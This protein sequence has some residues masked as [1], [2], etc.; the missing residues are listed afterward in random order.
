[1]ANVAP[2]NF[3]VTPSTARSGETLTFQWSAGSGD[4]VQYRVWGTKSTGGFTAS[5][6]VD[7][8]KLTATGTYPTDI[9]DGGYVNYR[10]SLAQADGGSI[11]SSDNFN[12]P[13]VAG[14][15]ETVQPPSSITVPNVIKNQSITIT[16]SE[17]TGATSYTLQRLVNSGSFET[18]YTGTALSYTDTVGSN[19]ETVQ[20]R[21][22]ATIGENTSDWKTSASKPVEDETI[23]F[24]GGYIM[25]L[26]DEQAKNI[27]PKTTTEAVF[28]KSDGKQ[29]DEILEGLNSGGGSGGDST[30]GG[31]S[32]EEVDRKIEQAKL[33]I[34][35]EFD[36]K[37]TNLR[38]ELLDE[39]N[40]SIVA[41]WEASY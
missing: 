41:V 5:V 1:M 6:Y 17:V 40:S 15:V 39:I 13:K 4:F 18:I 28:R 20:Y 38:T 25:Q 30:G 21:V 10:V 35:N 19:W 23:P 32:E 24:S 29:L 3:T 11:E 26:E 8:S 31:I 36:E 33:E 9:P 27:Y 12:V 37:I 14:S 7:K 2:S 16:W 34:E 22:S